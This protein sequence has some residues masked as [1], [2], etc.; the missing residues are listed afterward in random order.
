VASS[1]TTTFTCDAAGNQTLVVAP[2][3]SRTTFT[4]DDENRNT[5]LVLP[6][7]SIVTMSYRFDGLRYTKVVGATTTKFVYD[8]QNYLVETDSLSAGRASIL[9]GI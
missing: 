8:G 4:W 3:N 5:K 2:A 1:G 9:S 7:N 6:G